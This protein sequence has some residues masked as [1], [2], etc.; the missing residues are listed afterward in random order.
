[1]HL[2]QIKKD[3]P[4]QAEPVGGHRAHWCASERGLLLGQPRVRT[5][6]STSLCHRD[7]GNPQGMHSEMGRAILLLCLLLVRLPPPSFTAA[8]TTCCNSCSCSSSFALCSRSRFSSWVVF[9][10][11]SGSVMAKWSSAGPE[12]I[13][14]LPKERICSRCML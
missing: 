4:A 1:M 12:S 3:V 11:S 10:S 5:G 2:T 7:T 8:A 9:V 6:A 14:L 13:S